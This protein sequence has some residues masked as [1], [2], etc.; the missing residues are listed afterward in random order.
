MGRHQCTRFTPEPAIA[1]FF[2]ASVTGSQANF[3][4][5]QHILTLTF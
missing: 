3:H 2:I 1:K 4:I 5:P